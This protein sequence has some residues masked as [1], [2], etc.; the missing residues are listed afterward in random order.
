[1]VI[2]EDGS[3]KRFTANFTS[4]TDFTFPEAANYYD[5]RGATIATTLSNGSSLSMNTR[6]VAY[7]SNNFTTIRDYNYYTFTNDF[8]YHLNETIYSDMGFALLVSGVQNYFHSSIC[9]KSIKVSYG[10]TVTNQL[11]FSSI[12]G[13]NSDCIASINYNYPISYSG[14]Y[15]YAN[16]VNIVSLSNNNVYK[17]NINLTFRFNFTINHYNFYA[18]TYSYTLLYSSPTPITFLKATN[19]LLYMQS[20]SSGATAI[21]NFNTSQVGTTSNIPTNQTYS[22]FYVYGAYYM[23]QSTG[24]YTLSYNSAGNI[25]SY[26]SKVTSLPENFYSFL[27]GSY[28]DAFYV[29]GQP[30]VYKAGICQGQSFMNGTSCVNYSCSV[31]NCSSCNIS[32]TFCSVCNSGY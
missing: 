20:N 8:T 32:P 5:S 14:D 23:L 29:H 31:D 11:S 4:Y 30:Y 26:L 15:F 9:S 12:F 28:I 22:F 2:F 25:L 7:I 1:M 21:Y 3:A 10:G 6:N 24:I 18:W 16:F 19:S 27:W 13:A 17:F